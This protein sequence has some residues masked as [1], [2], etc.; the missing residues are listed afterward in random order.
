MK[1][2][3]DLHALARQALE[4]ARARDLSI[5]TAESCT[6]GKLA[7]LLSEVPAPPN[8]ST[9]ASSPTQRTPRP[10]F[11]MCPWLCLVRGVQSVVR[12]RSQW[13]VARADGQSSY[14]SMNYGDI[15]RENVQRQAM[16][17]AVRQLVWFAGQ[18]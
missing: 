18:D 8:G 10:G 3:D 17:D 1:F 15:G 14:I 9:A 2:G 5:A 6:A 16:A 4:L 12:S 13:R 11:L 7:V